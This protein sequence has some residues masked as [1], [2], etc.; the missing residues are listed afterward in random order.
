M[1]PQIPLGLALR[2]GATFDNYCAGPN[3][4]VV[5]GL[6]ACAVGRGD[7]PVYMWGDQGLGKTHLL[8]AAC[9]HSGNLQQPSAY[10]PLCEAPKLPIAILE[11]LESMALVCIDDIHVIAGQSHWEV[12]LFNLFNRI[13]EQGVRLLMASCLAPDKMQLVLP[14]LRSRLAWGP[15]SPDWVPLLRCPRS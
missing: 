2:T 13:R 3:S 6:Q 10:L 1:N 4:E 12:A 5:R 8:Q 15:P 11:G 7:S 9:A 14:D